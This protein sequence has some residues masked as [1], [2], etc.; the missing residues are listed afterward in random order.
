MVAGWLSITFKIEWKDIALRKTNKIF[1]YKYKTIL[2]KVIFSST[3]IKLSHFFLKR[4]RRR[5]S[6]SD[7]KIIIF[8]LN[9][10]IYGM[11]IE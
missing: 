2:S 7:K 10:A 6:L 9:H 4:S 3:E 1:I 5:T 11:W 8:F